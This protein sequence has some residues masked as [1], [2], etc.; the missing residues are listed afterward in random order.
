MVGCVVW[1]AACLMLGSLLEL[2]GSGFVAFLASGLNAMD[3]GSTFGFTVVCCTLGLNAI[4]PGAT[5]G[6]IVGC[7]VLGSPV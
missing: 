6:F 7:C 4:D 2:T 3:P 1:P 5:F